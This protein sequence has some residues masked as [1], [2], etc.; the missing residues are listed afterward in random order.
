MPVGTHCVLSAEHRRLP[1]PSWHDRGA[2]RHGNDV[3]SAMA[4]KRPPDPSPPV[5]HNPFAAL[6]ALRDELPAGDDPAPARPPEAAAP[7]PLGKLVVRR[8]KK[9]RGGKTVTRVSGLPPARLA[10]LARDVKRALGCGATTE[11]DD[12]VLLGSVV[13]RAAAHLVEL[14]ARE[15]VKGS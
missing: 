9:G 10:E 5:A 6:S 7:P 14:G 12:L 13:D 4:K 1:V 11:G 2:A 3:S 15:I 8:E